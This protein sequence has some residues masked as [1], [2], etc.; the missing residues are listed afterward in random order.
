MENCKLLKASEAEIEA[1]RSEGFD[2]EV[3]LKKAAQHQERAEVEMNNRVIEAEDEIQRVGREVIQCRR[4]LKESELRFD[5][6]AEQFAKER[7]FLEKRYLNEKE[8]NKEIA[9]GYEQR[10]GSLK[11]ELKLAEKDISLLKKSNNFLEKRVVKR[12]QGSQFD[13]N[14]KNDMKKLLG[15]SI[16]LTSD[17]M[18]FAK[19]EK[20]MLPLFKTCTLG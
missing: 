7:E 8:R 1:M 18:N 19:G 17:I 15:I 13:E 4:L 11:E 5:R 3:K 9:F 16:E 6:Q 10:I 12:E 2:L 20:A 14:F